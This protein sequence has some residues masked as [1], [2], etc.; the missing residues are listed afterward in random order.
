MK[1]FLFIFNPFKYF[2]VLNDNRKV[3][4][5]NNDLKMQIYMKNL[6]NMFIFR[7]FVGFILGDSVLTLIFCF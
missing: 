1:S 3:C 4:Y 2:K 6:Y 7:K 5:S